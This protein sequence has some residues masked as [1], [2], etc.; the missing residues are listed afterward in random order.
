MTNKLMFFI[1]NWKMYGENSLIR[2]IKTLHEA[3]IKFK[4]KNKKNKVVLCI[5]Y[6]LINFFVKKKKIKSISIGAQNCHHESLGPFT[7]SI[8]AKMVKDVGA[9]YIIIGHSENRSDG[10]TNKKIKMK[11]KLAQENKLNIIFCIGETLN[12]KKTKKTFSVLKKQLSDS[13]DKSTNSKKIIIAYEP[14]WSIG[15]GRTPKSN[16]LKKIFLFLKNTSKK[17]LHAKSYPAII[18]GGSVN[19]KNVSI[20]SSISEIDGFLIGGASLS[21][22]KFIAIIKNYYK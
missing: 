14:V 17:I 19:D 10:D 22:K 20:F 6:T 3:S 12:E 5:P 18:Y 11:I 13:I 4:N 7:G 16:E 8:S 2:I 1:G 21:V 15:T 9:E